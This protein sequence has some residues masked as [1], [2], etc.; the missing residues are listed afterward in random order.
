MARPRGLWPAGPKSQLL[1]Y[2]KQ[3]ST[4]PGQG[5]ESLWLGCKNS[6]KKSL[7]N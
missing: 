2:P 3:R 7:M 6:S 4:R 1:L 5:K